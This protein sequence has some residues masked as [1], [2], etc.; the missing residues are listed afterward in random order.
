MS[1]DTVSAM[2]IRWR[3]AALVSATA[4]ITI[5]LGAC[6][7]SDSTATGGVGPSSASSSGATTSAAGSATPSG[8]TA[9]TID[10]D[11]PSTT[12]PNAEAVPGPQLPPAT[13][14]PPSKRGPNI[15]GARCDTA[16]GPEGALR[17]VIF[18]GGS[19]GCP[20]VMPVAK[21]YGP[22]ISSGR[23]QTVDGWN[24]G[25]SQTPGVLAKCARGADSFG[26]VPQ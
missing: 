7:D 18:P 6:G 12:D 19:A 2:Q 5:G 8:S 1:F 16:N 4:A 15:V 13:A 14:V 20:T 25:P 17:V 11:A 26:F 21:K 3:T 22:M 10:P 23:D 9:P 24:C